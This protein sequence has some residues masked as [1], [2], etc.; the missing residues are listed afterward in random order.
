ML[1]TS[2]HL[3]NTC[4]KNEVRWPV[5]MESC[6]AQNDPSHP[7][8]EPTS[9]RYGSPVARG[10]SARDRD[11]RPPVAPD[12]SSAGGHDGAGDEVRARPVGRRRW[13]RAPPPALWRP[14]PAW[15]KP[16]L[17]VLQARGVRIRS[18]LAGRRR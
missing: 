2:W 11:H 4:A 18:A 14:R 17:G 7:T 13:E 16:G 5:V 15:G 10:P 12:P 9:G 8:T 3:I 1:M 6:V